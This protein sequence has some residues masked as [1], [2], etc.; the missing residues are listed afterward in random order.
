MFFKKQSQSKSNPCS[1]DPCSA[2][3][4][5]SPLDGITS[6][7]GYV[8]ATHWN[9]MR[10]YYGSEPSQVRGLR[11]PSVALQSENPELADIPALMN[12]RAQWNL[13]FL[14]ETNPE[15]QF[16][17]ATDLTSEGVDSC[18]CSEAFLDDVAWLSQTI[19]IRL[20]TEDGFADS[21]DLEL[22]LM[23]TV[24]DLSRIMAKTPARRS[25]AVPQSPV[26]PASGDDS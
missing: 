6:R 1:S 24:Q 5:P 18:F 8:P 21:I 10:Q 17:P 11:M 15:H 26:T 19:E 9:E 12:R 7:D 22:G 13:S 20:D 14:P 4:E 23:E 16:S 3:P 2:V 25:S